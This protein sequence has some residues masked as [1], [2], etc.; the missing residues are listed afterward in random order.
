MTNPSATQPP[1]NALFKTSVLAWRA[2][3]LAAKAARGSGAPAP[4]NP[5][6]S[7]AAIVKR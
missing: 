3:Y 2:N 6:A 7:P 1:I 5:P 4:A